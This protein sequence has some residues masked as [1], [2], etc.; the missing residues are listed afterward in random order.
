MIRIRAQHAG[1]WGIVLLG[2]AGF[3]FSPLVPAQ[4]DAGGGKPKPKQEAAKSSPPVHTVKAGTFRI[5]TELDGILEAETMTPISL[6]PDVFKT[7]EVVKAVPHGTE[8]KQGEPLI[9]LETKDLDEQI[10]ET[11][12]AVELGELSIKDAKEDLE[13]FEATM[14][15]DLAIA[16]RANR[17]AQR[18]LSQYV[19]TDRPLAV[20]SAKQSLKNSVGQLENATEEL[21]QLEKMYKADDLTEETEEIILKRARRSVESAELYAEL[22]KVRADRTLQETIPE[23]EIQLTEAA[24]RQE[25]SLAKVKATLPVE[26]RRKAIALEKL[27]RSQKK[28][29][30]KLD[31]LKQDRNLLDVTA[32]SAGV[33]YYGS[34]QDG[35]WSSIDTASKQ[36]EP[37]KTLAPNQVFMTIVAL[38]PLQVRLSVA[39][40]DVRF[41]ER[42]MSG[43]AVPTAFPDRKLPVKISSVAR[44]PGASTKFDALASIKLDEADALVPGMTCKVKLTSYEKKD[45]LTIPEKAVF[46]DEE[47]KAYVWLAGDPPEK[48]SVETG[49]TNSGKV[50]ITQ[51]LKAGDK[52]LTEKP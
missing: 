2:L 26:R 44:I 38:R 12:L 5:E 30:E 41:L 11:E 34:C 33:V 47:G 28:L 22:A 16:E 14:P 35:K 18:E 32:P 6:R 46:H 24:Q 23:K 39:E 29:V 40:K 13:F 1:I 10:R 48:Q 4:E 3:V 17:V 42:G 20:R 8:V 45:A 36:L 37:G 7:L 21:R 19:E 49:K 50:E 52:I 27:V 51:G 43:D 31:K 25:L 9:W 15:L